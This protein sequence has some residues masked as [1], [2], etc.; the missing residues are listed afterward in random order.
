M[1]IKH[2]PLIQWRTERCVPSFRGEG[3]VSALCKVRLLPV[4]GVSTPRTSF[5]TASKSFLFPRSHSPALRSNIHRRITVRAF[6]QPLDGAKRKQS[7]LASVPKAS[8][9]T[10]E[11]SCFRSRHPHRQRTSKSQSP[12]RADDKS[13]LRLSLAWERPTYPA[14]CRR[15]TAFGPRDLDTHDSRFKTN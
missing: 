4:R 8:I 3:W 14:K 12:H 6:L 1:T 5:L 15:E 2:P 10:V 11:N 9:E 13:A 7:G